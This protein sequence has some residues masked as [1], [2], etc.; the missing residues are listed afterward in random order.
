MDSRGTKG[1]NPDMD[2][3]RVIKHEMSGRS[4]RRRV[5]HFFQKDG[6]LAGRIILGKIPE[7]K[8]AEML[9][10]CLLHL[11]VRAI[12]EYHNAKTWS[13]VM[14]CNNKLA[15]ELSSHHKR[16][17]RP[18]AK[19]ADIRQS[20]RAT[21]QTYTGYFLYA[22]IYGHMDKYLSQTQLSLMQQLNCI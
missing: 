1:R 11:L 10:L 5:D 21:K 8:L 12:T 4:I 17:I 6:P 14:S 13:A 9:D 3:G 2:N 18:N 22:H 20:F 16:R 19:C 15:L 7:G